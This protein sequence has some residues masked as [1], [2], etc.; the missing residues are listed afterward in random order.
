M[1]PSIASSHLPR[2][3]TGLILAGVLV[4][5]LIYGGVALLSALLIISFIGQLEFYCLF[6][7]GRSKPFSKLLGLLCGSGIIYTAFQAAGNGDAGGPVF[8]AWLVGV[9]LIAAL[10]FLFQ[11]GAYNDVSFA[12]F[13]VLPLGVLYIPFILQAAFGLS[14][15]EQFLVVGAAVAS[16]TGGYYVGSLFGKHKLWVRISP[17]KSWEGSLGGLLFCILVTIMIGFLYLSPGVETDGLL[18]PASVLAR[19]ALLGILLNLAAQCGDFFE[20]ALKRSRNVKD[21]SAILPGHGGILD[22]ID[23][24]LFTVAVYTLVKDSL[25]TEALARFLGYIGL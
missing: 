3:L 23:S 2:L 14:L 22:R 17:K 16:D 11:Y 12:E 1:I 18:P 21:S 20:S 24:I 10:F 19:W 6:W 4:G 7:P 9:T 25:H 13:A 5:C 15:P 8:Q